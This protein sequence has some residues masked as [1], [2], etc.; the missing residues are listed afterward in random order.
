MKSSYE[1]LSI[2]EL[3]Y[4]ICEEDSELKESLIKY[5]DNNEDIKEDD[6]I[7]SF[8]NTVRA[9]VKLI[10]RFGIDKKKIISKLV[11]NL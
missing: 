8:F 5:G 7:D 2:T 10:E 9:R 3:I 6:V 1:Y 11:E 4:K